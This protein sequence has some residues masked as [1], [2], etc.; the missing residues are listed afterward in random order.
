ML[1][2]IIMV[3]CIAAAAAAAG[4]IIHANRK[5]ETQKYYDAA[6]KVIKEGCLNNAIRNKNEKIQNGQKMMI[7][8]KWKDSERQGYVFDPK[9]PIR[10]GRIPD[11]NDICIREETVSSHHCVLYLYK[12]QVYLRDLN[13]RNGTWLRQGIRKRRI[14]GAEPVFSGDVVIVGKLAVRL[15]IFSFD[16]AYV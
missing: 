15:T 8:L 4:Y 13:S 11:D 5:A 9:H 1:I 6:Y 3:I 2:G 16:M 7:Y 10:I 14:E 12:G